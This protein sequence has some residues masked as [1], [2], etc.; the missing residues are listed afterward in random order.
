[1]GVS[2][3]RFL[4]VGEK[5]YVDAEFCQRKWADIQLDR[6]NKGTGEEFALDVCA[7]ANRESRPVEAA[8]VNISLFQPRRFL[9]L[10]GRKQDVNGSND[11]RCV[12]L[13]ARSLALGADSRRLHTKKLMS[14]RF[15]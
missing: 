9:T 2:V 10:L 4:G 11:S 6:H 14:R 8:A 3:F 12:V 5:M 13:G 7:N 1:M 15:I